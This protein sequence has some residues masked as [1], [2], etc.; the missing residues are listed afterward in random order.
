MAIT[1]QQNPIRQVASGRGYVP[2][3]PCVWSVSSSNIA[4]PNFK[5]LIQIFDGATEVAKFV[6]APNPYDRCHFDAW[7]VN[8]SYVRPDII[9]ASFNS[10]HYQGTTAAPGNK[11]FRTALT[12]I[13]KLQIRFGEKYDVLGTPTEFPGA[14]TLGVVAWDMYIL[15]YRTQFADGLNP[16]GNGRWT[17]T[18][19]N[20]R[21]PLTAWRSGYF[22]G[23][24]TTAY[25]LGTAI[26]I[27]VTVN[28]WGVMSFPHDSLTI[29]SL[30][31][32]YDLNYAI[33]NG[34]TLL[35]SQITLIT[36]G[37]GAASPTSTTATDKLVYFAAYPKNLSN[38]NVITNPLYWP[39]NTFNPTW[40][41][42]TITIRTSGGNASSQALVFYRVQP[43]NCRFDNMR[44]AFW[45]DYG[46]WD[47]FNFTKKNEINW[48]KQGK[49]YDK[50]IGTFED[51]TYYQPGNT[52]STT[53]YGQ[54]VDKVYTVT[55]NWITEGMSTYLRQLFS[56]REVRLL[57]TANVTDIP[58]TVVEG[59]Y[60]EEK[61]R[62]S[63]VVNVTFQIKLSQPLNI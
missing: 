1:I 48:T 38:L 8:K 42:Y 46:G 32:T 10:I 20:P 29:D 47:Y 26:Q 51:T 45:N 59:S 3:G 35:G 6:I 24:N 33:Y 49:T 37:N 21:P 44:L 43:D 54:I 57:D 41:H 13:K 16:A 53:V 30:N 36:A 19:L 18:N 11:P 63:R 9:D 58:V 61:I 52:R 17:L 15:P 50:I 27:P 28:D 2:L 34:N 40:T 22:K 5:F 4:Q 31:N 12:A 7:E 25:S 39:D 23:D 62:S 14:S 55:S 60:K 56:S